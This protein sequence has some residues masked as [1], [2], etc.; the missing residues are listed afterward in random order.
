VLSD[1]GNPK[2]SYGEALRH[3]GLEFD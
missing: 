1:V 3:F 2:A